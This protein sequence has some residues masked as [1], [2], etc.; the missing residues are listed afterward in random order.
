MN[1][2]RSEMWPA[3]RKASGSKERTLSDLI[4]NLQ[5]VRFDCTFG[6]GCDG[7]CCKEGRP[8]VY[9]D[10]IERIDANLHKFLPQ[11]RPDARA[12]IE[13]RRYLTQRRRA[14]QPMLRV[15][16]GWCVFFHEGCVLHK[17]GASEGDKFRYKPWVCAT[18][19]IGRGPRNKWYVRQAGLNKEKWDLLCIRPGA[20][21]VPAATSLREE[22]MLVESN[23]AAFER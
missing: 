22:V 13:K 17:T 15:V 11:L 23:M 14:G 10:E 18:F 2:A 7:I 21:S 16:S 9:P 12:A 5:Q 8:P 6:R 3:V 4:V 19:P 20:S 1:K